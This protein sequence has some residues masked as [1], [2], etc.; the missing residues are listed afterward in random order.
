LLDRLAALVPPPRVHRHRYY[1]VLAPNSPLRTA[2]TALAPGATTAPPAPI[3]EP[4]AA[5]A[6]WELRDAHATPA[7]SVPRAPQR[8]PHHPGFPSVRTGRHVLRCPRRRDGGV[9]FPIRP[10]SSRRGRRSSCASSRRS[11]SRTPTRTARARNRSSTRSAS[12]SDPERAVPSG[13]RADRL[14]RHA[15]KPDLPGTWIGRG[16]APG[17]AAARPRVGRVAAL[18]P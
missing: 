3:A 5:G 4:A 18:G 9:G 12:S 11:T 16:G 15:E 8:P 10:S 2:V 1:G 7:F 6:R 14:R 13:G 17:P